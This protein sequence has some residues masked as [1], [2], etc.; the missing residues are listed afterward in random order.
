MRRSYQVLVS[1]N[2]M[3]CLLVYTNGYYIMTFV[4]SLCKI[5]I[6]RGT[7]VFMCKGSNLTI[8]WYAG[9]IVARRP[10]D[11]MSFRIEPTITTWRIVF[12]YLYNNCC[13]D[14]I[15]LIY[16]H[17]CVCR[18]SLYFFSVRHNSNARDTHQTHHCVLRSKKIDWSIDVINY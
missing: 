8:N 18:L 7:R 13:W 1:A 4:V 9:T 12:L 11:V 5:I 17:V 2:T 3:M 15:M 14:T 6:S 10:N 16:I